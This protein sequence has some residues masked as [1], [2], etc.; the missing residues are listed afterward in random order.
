MT[1]AGLLQSI[2]EEPGDEVRL[3]C[4]DW[5]EEQ[6]EPERADFI[7]VQVELARLAHAQR[8]PAEAHRR[9]MLAAREQTLLDE[10]YRAWLGPL[11]GWNVCP[12]FTRGFVEEIDGRAENFLRAPEVVFALHPIHRLHLRHTGPL[13]P[14]VI[15]RPEL[16]CLETLGL[17]NNEVQ[18]LEVEALAGSPHL[19]RLHNLDLSGNPIGMAGAVAL[20]ES[21]YL[22][23][24]TRFV[25]FGTS[26]PAEGIRL[27]RQRFGAALLA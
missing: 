10:H 8:G 18:D 26:V 24:L 14:A 25:L 9:D 7:R 16:A 2:R 5:Y 15:G 17:A 3:V 13:L 27:L 21:P 11:W 1:L 19:A 23:N 6:G 12:E 22:G 20:A 4:A